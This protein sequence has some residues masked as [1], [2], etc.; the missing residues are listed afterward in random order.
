LSQNQG[1]MALAE[2]PNTISTWQS[3]Y[4]AVSVRKLAQLMLL[5]K[6]LI[7]ST[8]LSFTRNFFTT[9]KSWLK[10][11]TSGNPNSQELWRLNSELDDK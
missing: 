2:Q 4:S 9:R 7:L 11:G 10:M 1:P 6:D 3:A 8:Q 5:W